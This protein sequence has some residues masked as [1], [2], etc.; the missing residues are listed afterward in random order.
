MGAQVVQ[1]NQGSV[2]FSPYEIL[3]V[4]DAP[5]LLA[6]TDSILRHFANCFVDDVRSLFRE[7]IAVNVCDIAIGSV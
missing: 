4:A 5:M 7:Q 6:P 2:K 1:E 3:I